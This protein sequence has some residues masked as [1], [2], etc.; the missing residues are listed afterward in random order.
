M[1]HVLV[2]ISGFTRRVQ[3]F[4][5]SD[6]AYMLFQL[7]LSGNPTAGARIQG[8]GGL[9]KIRWPDTRRGKGRR[10]GLRIIYL[11]LPSLSTIVLFDVYDKNEQD[12]L[13]PHER[14]ALR[15]VVDSVVR[16]LEPPRPM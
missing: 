9:R 13:S 15:E 2:E 4:F 5:P 12:D 11:H 3:T 8:C 14:Q 16:S 10:G 7:F 1:K 6:E